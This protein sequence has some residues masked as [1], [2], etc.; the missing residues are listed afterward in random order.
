MKAPLL[1]IDKP[2]FTPVDFFIVSMAV[3]VFLSVIFRYFPSIPEPKWRFRS[4]LGKL[5]FFDGVVL[6]GLGFI[7]IGFTIKLIEII[8]LTRI[9]I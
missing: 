7:V 1:H 5:P 6:Y 9:N 8:P 3:I 4:P 2:F